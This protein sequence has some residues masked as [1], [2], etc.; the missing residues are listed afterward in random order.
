[1]ARSTQRCITCTPSDW[2]AIQALAAESGMKT[3]PFI[4]SRVL[5]GGTRMA[6]TADEQRRQH[7]RVAR[8]VLV[9]EDLLRPL[10]GCDMTLGEAVA[11]LLRDRQTA[12]EAAADHDVG[13]PPA[14]PGEGRFREFPGPGG[15]DSR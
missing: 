9:C 3:S 13:Q 5:G 4:L 11:F 6:L 12:Q 10:P 8:L 14:R 1:M 15:N 2:R 7:D